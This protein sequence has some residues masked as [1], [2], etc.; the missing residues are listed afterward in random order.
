[1]SLEKYGLL[2][3]KQICKTC[4]LPVNFVNKRI[5]CLSCKKSV[6][7]VCSCEYDGELYCQKCWDDIGKG[8][9]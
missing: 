8:N 5:P 2:K 3:P 4:Y 7:V 6:C 9:C 1:M